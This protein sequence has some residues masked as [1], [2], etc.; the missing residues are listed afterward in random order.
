MPTH[1]FPVAAEGVHVLIVASSLSS[2]SRSRKL[3]RIA[4]G[5]LMAAGIPATLLDLNETPLPSAGSSAGWSDPNVARIKA[6]TTA[7]TQVLF[8]VPIYNYDVNSVA[9]NFI[10]LMGEDAL[11]GKTVGFL[12]SAGGKGSYMSILGFANSLMLDFR[13]WIVP[14]FVYVSEDFGETLPAEIESRMDELLHDLLN[15]GIPAAA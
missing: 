5:K 3:A 13:C 11:G 6:A 1:P 12:C 7:A 8:A 14:R 4:H 15:R 2:K 10:E 9:K